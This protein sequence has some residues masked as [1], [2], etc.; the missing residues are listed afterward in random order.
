MFIW[1]NSALIN[2]V[3]NQYICKNLECEEDTGF[4]TCGNHFIGGSGAEDLHQDPLLHGTRN[5]A[6]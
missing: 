2:S 3:A 4:F 5:S 6:I 1:V